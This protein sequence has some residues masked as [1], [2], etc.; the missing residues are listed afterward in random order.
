MTTAIDPVALARTTAHQIFE[1]GRDYIALLVGARLRV[2]A[3]GTW[4]SANNVAR[5]AILDITVTPEAVATEATLV[6]ALLASGIV[7]QGVWLFPDSL[8]QRYFAM[9]R[10]GQKTPDGI[11]SGEYDLGQGSTEERALKAAL[12]KLLAT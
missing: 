3:D 11:E 7:V 2:Y 4:K 8:D 12:D 1:S 5:N 10:H 9:F 6:R